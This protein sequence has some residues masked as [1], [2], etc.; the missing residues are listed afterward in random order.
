MGPCKN[1]IDIWGVGVWE[2]SVPNIYDK[3]CLCS[4]L[5]SLTVSALFWTKLTLLIL[6]L[7]SGI[8][9]SDL[10]GCH[11]KGEHQPFSEA[12]E[13]SERQSHRVSHHEYKRRNEYKPRNEAHE[14]L[15]LKKTNMVT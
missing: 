9:L 15:A 6:F 2:P 4:G 11:H 8:V 12:P 13:L 14:G 7:W 5:C 1:N 3:P 10:E